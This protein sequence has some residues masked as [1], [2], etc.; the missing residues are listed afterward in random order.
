MEF[1]MNMEFL[2][3]E[4]E[5]DS[6]LRSPMIGFDSAALGRKPDLNIFFPSI[7]MGGSRKGRVMP[8]DGWTV[9][10]GSVTTFYTISIEYRYNFCCRSF[11]QCHT[12]I[13]FLAMEIML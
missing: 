10:L 5:M 3:N 6:N 12:T 9:R 7:S 13:Q 1:A 8:R 11:S 4:L 2:R